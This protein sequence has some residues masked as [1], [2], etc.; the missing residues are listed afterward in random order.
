MSVDEKSQ[1]QA[2]DRTQRG[3]SLKK[4]R[5]GTMTHDYKRHG[6][7][8]L[9]AALNV[10]GGTVISMCEDRHRHPGHRGLEAGRGVDDRHPAAPQMREERRGRHR[11]VGQLDVQ[12]PP[13]L[14]VIR[15]PPGARHV[16]MLLGDEPHSGGQPHPEP[17]A[18]LELVGELE[19][20]FDIAVPLNALTHIRTVGQIAAEVGRLVGQESA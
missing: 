5:C 2:L 18:Q 16:G 20:H 19:D 7:A 9:F 8:T 4:G 12:E 13:E 10:A 1:I 17:P 6:T 14:G 11:G 3:L 15:R